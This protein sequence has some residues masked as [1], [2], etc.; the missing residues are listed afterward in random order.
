GWRP[1]R[2]CAGSSV[3]EAIGVQTSV[4]GGNGA[5]TVPGGPAAY[6]EADTLP[7]DSATMPTSGEEKKGLFGFLKFGKKKETPPSAPAPVVNDQAV[8]EPVPGQAPL[9]PATVGVE[10]L[11]PSEQ[12][13]L[14]QAGISG[15]SV[16]PVA[17]PGTA[18]A[19]SPGEGTGA[20]SQPSPANSVAPPASTGEA[21]EGEEKEKMVPLE[22]M[23]RVPKGKPKIEVLF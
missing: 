11:T 1:R 22:P 20:T 5:G 10:Q 7:A 15:V 17:T 6:T 8:V 14:Q 23:K 2:C 13:F 3:A 18:S 21:P 19:V 12:A 9:P 4:G 16:A